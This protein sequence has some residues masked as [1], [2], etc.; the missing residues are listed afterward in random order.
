[1]A[2][3]HPDRAGRSRHRLDAADSAVDQQWSVFVPAPFLGERVLGLFAIALQT[4]DGRVARRERMGSVSAVVLGS[5]AQLHPALG[6]P[7]PQ[8]RR[9][10]TPIGV[11]AMRNDVPTC[12]E[13]HVTPLADDRRRGAVHD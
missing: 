8:P 11:Y 3:D 7:G 2:L 12:V 9:H 13:T 4:M 6:E 10:A 1:M 5:V